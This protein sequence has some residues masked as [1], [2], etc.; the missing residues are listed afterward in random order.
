MH[1]EKDYYTLQML[2]VCV[3]MSLSVYHY[4]KR[5]HKNS[6]LWVTH[7]IVS[8]LSYK[9]LEVTEYSMMINTLLRRTETTL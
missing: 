5:I 4:H 7:W 3:V 8:C 2:T 9:I 6:M 1:H